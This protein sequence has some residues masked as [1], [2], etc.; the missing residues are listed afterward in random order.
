MLRVGV[1]GTGGID[2]G[3]VDG[4]YA[5]WFA[6]LGTDAVIIRP[7]FYV[8]TATDAMTLAATLGRLRSQLSMER[9]LQS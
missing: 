5:Q 3:D 8:Y 9:R 2:V 4:R 1:P 7:D 6:E